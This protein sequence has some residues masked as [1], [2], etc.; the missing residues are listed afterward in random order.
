MED[1]LRSSEARYRALVET[2]GDW[3]WEIDRNGVYTYASPKIKDV[4]GY[5]VDEIIGKTPFDLMPPEEAKR[6]A[7]EFQKIAVSFS[8]FSGLENANVHKDGRLVVIETSGTPLFD[9]EGGYSGYTGFDRDVTSRK[10]AEEALRKAE[11]RYRSIFENAPYGICQVTP[12]GRYLSANPAMVRMFGYDSAEELMET[13]S[14]AGHQPLVN[15]ADGETLTS[16][17]SE[18]GKVE[19]FETRIFRKDG[20]P[21]WVSLGIRVARDADG[22]ILYYEATNEDITERKQAEEALQES[23]EALWSL[24]N[25]TMESLLL[26]DPEGKILI[27]NETVAQRLGKSVGEVIGTCQYDYFPQE[28]ADFRKAQYA[29]VLRTGKPVRFEDSRI[30]RLFESCAYPVFDDQGAVSKIAIFATDITERRKGEEEKTKL[31]AQLLQSQKIE[32]IGTLAGGI[33][34]DFN[35][36]LTALIGYG[37]LLQMGLGKDNP[38]SVHV[39]HILSSSEKAAQLTQSLLTFSRKQPVALKPLNLNDTIR[40]TE[41]LLGRLLTEDIQLQTD[42]TPDDTTVMGDATQIDQILFNLATNARDAMPLGGTLTIETGRV[43]MDSNFIRDHGYG[44]TGTYVLISVSDTGTGMDEETKRHIFDPFFTTKEVGRGTGLGLSTIYG[45]VVQHN[46]YI[47][48]SS[49]PGRG[50]IFHIYFPA[51]TAA[52]ENEEPAS[53]EMSQGHETILVAED[54]EGVRSLVKTIL[55]KYGYTII[56]AVD[57]EDAVRQFNAHE[58]IDLLIIDSVMPK[59]NGRQ[60]YDEIYRKNRHIRVLFMSGY[61]RDIVL[62]KGIEEKSFHFISKPL[63]PNGLL[64]KVREVLDSTLSLH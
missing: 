19:K 23:R 44:K 36:I 9:K 10:Q 62:D 17:L 28:T 20:K 64:R 1:V 11:E 58:D 37:T 32:A 22:K 41:R 55:S 30:G 4:L 27:A 38:L 45:V 56:E 16:L 34:H 51:V 50:T 43:E 49:E 47:N 33:A 14:D 40:G 61:T 39:D 24:I 63:S 2:T 7:V 12:E 8:P 52:V 48:V 53:V 54:N 13:V 46:G 21:I 59:K 3:I 5:T 15:P 25:A 35:N 60:V 26:V 6:V 31:E 18:H 29:A 42:L 57:G